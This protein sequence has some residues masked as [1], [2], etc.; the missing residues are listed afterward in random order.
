MVPTFYDQDENGLPRRWVEKM[1][2][3]IES[4]VPRFS[5]HRMLRD[6]VEKFYLP[7]AARRMDTVSS[8]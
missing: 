6:Y 8:K 1:K 7:A 3:S 5:A 4:V 2:A